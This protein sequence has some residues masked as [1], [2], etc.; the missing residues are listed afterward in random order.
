MKKYLQ[1]TAILSAFVLAVLV[2][3][4]YASPDQRQEV[5]GMIGS[6]D[7]SNDSLT[8]TVVLPT[9]TEA[10]VPTP[11]PGESTPDPNNCWKPRTSHRRS[12]VPYFCRQWQL[13]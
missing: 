11:R 13:V 4:L 8:P 9:P 7:R 5:A 3:R 12:F 10:P 1:R 6:A 2:H